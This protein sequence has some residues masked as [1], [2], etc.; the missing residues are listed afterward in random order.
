[1]AA[2]N[3]LVAGVK[4]F[5]ERWLDTSL[6]ARCGTDEDSQRRYAKDL[7]QA[8]YH[9]TRAH[10]EWVADLDF[11][12]LAGGVLSALPVSALPHEASRQRFMRELRSAVKPDQCFTERV[13]VTLL[14]G[15]R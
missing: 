1:M 4:S 10:H 3:R 8:E 7:E 6:T 5:L 15:R 13:P 12:H 14:I 11:E 2:R 9:V